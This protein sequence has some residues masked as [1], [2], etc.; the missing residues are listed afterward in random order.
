MQ[1]GYPGHPGQVKG[2]ARGGGVEVGGGT[3]H[4]LVA[5]THLV[6]V[7]VQGP[8]IWIEEQLVGH[9]VDGR[10]AASFVAHIPLRID[11]APEAWSWQKKKKMDE[12]RMSRRHSNGYTER[13]TKVVSGIFGFNTINR[14]I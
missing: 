1:M 4:D 7:N 13:Y 3:P 9:H 5:S 6:L 2:L 8:Q 11:E 10:L 14:R 12:K